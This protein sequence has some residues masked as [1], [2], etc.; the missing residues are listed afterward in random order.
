MINQLRSANTSKTKILNKDDYDV[1]YRIRTYR[2]AHVHSGSTEVEISPTDVTVCLN[3]IS[4][5]E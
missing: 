3:I 4:V 2:N 1:L 5:L